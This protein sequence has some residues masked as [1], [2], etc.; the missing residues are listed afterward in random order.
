M[1]FDELITMIGGKHRRY[2]ASRL[3]NRW[4]AKFNCGAT[5]HPGTFPIL[6]QDYAFFTTIDLRCLCLQA[7]KFSW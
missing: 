3:S 5:V 4:I 2:R 7:Q 1:V 6:R